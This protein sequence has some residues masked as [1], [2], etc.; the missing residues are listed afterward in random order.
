MAVLSLA[1]TERCTT[2]PH[3][4]TPTHTHTC[5][6][7]MPVVLTTL[8]KVSGGNWWP[9]WPWWPSGWLPVQSPRQRKCSSTCKTGPWAWGSP[10]RGLGASLALAP[11]LP[12]AVAVGSGSTEYSVLVVGSSPG[13]TA[14][15]F[16]IGNNL[17]LALPSLE[18]VMFHPL[19]F[20]F[21][22]FQLCPSRFPPNVNAPIRSSENF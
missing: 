15:A 2:H 21:S 5:P 4:L 7:A 12:L 18:L 6:P 17:E 3:P 20:N 10:G 8:P 14:G 13:I 16:G 22:P 19:L 9:W 1:L 11:I